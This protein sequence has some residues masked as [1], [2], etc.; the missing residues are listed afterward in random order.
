MGWNHQLDNFDNTV[1]VP[2]FFRKKNKDIGEVNQL[3]PAFGKA[4]GVWG[5]WMWIA[6][7]F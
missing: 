5:R 1:F 4:K 2:S 3:G 7:D 6:E